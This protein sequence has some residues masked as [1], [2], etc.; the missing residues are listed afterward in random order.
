MQPPVVWCEVTIGEGRANTA[1]REWLLDGYVAP[2]PRLALRWLDAWAPRLANRID[3]PL[4]AVWLE[5]PHKIGAIRVV[6]H[7]A[8]D[9]ATPLRAWPYDTELHDEALAAISDGTVFRIAVI[10]RHG[11]YSLSARPLLTRA[12]PH[13]CAP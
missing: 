1:A 2:S 7:N 8:P 12:E 6:E 9:P 4:D 10:D 13:G 3:P 5:G 11:F